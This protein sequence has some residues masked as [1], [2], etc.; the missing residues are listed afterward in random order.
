VLVDMLLFYLLCDPSMLGWSMTFS[1]LLAAELAIVN[2]FLWN[3][4]WTFRDAAADQTSARQKI[5]RFAKFNVIC[6]MGVAINVI[7]LNLQ[8]N[9]LGTNRYLANAIAIGLV[10]MWNFWL[11]SRLSWRVTEARHEEPQL[12]LVRPAPALRAS[13]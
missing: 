8:S 6:A 10:T 12:R 2:N 1:K 4:A 7:L 5:K 11:N 9:L 13:R 3:D